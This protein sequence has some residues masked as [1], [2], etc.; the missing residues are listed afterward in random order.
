MTKPHLRFLFDFISPY[1]HI[2][3]AL[4]TR[5]AAEHDRE[6]LPIPILFAALLNANGQKGPAE[7][8]K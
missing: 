2:G 8:S 6:V 3:W 4:V 1:A 5:I 7:N